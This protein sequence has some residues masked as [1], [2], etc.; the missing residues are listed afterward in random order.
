MCGEDLP[1]PPMRSPP[2]MA[3]SGNTPLA[4]LE[5]PMNAKSL[6]LTAGVALVVVVA[7]ERSKGK[8][9]TL[10]IKA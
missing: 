5:Y 1:A 9:P 4:R 2:L 8:I 6:L 10:N 3:P 7:Y